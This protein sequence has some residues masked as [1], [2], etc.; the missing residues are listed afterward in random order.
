V[1][2]KVGVEHYKEKVAILHDHGLVS[3]GTFILGGDGDGPDIFKRTADFVL[4]AKV[5][6]SHFGL[7][8][9][10]PG[11]ILWDRLQREGRLLYTDFPD[12]YA[13]YDL[14]TV[15]FRPLKMTVEQLQE[16]I[17][18][19]A[20]TFGSR[21]MTARRAW[22]TFWIIRDPRLASVAFRYHRSGF[23]NRIL[24]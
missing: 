21:W 15:T 9:P 6:V 16:G 14:R 22:N 11:T 3:S 4:D 5:D 17:Q 1:N 12:D 8:T 19:L 20:Q 10:N 18:W 24:D 7:M 23:A 2:L 13:R